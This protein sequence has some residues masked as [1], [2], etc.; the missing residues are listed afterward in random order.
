MTIAIN[1]ARGSAPIEFAIDRPMGI[2]KAAV[3]VFDIKLVNTQEIIKTAL[4]NKNG[5]AWV[6]LPTY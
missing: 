1:T 4:N 3:A 2:S 5:E 6:M